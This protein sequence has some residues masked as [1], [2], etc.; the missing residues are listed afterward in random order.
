[1]EIS[2]KSGS[3]LSYFSTYMYDFQAYWGGGNL[4]IFNGKE[5]PM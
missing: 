2:T 5:N 4:M 3:V 1:M